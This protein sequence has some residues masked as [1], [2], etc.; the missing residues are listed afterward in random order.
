M[1]K[2]I[3]FFTK[4]NFSVETGPLIE[5]EFHILRLLIYQNRVCHDL[6]PPLMLLR[7]IEEAFV[8]GDQRQG[9]LAAT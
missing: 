2:I 5:D 6:P 3:D 7:L 4:M 8:L 9:L 1:D